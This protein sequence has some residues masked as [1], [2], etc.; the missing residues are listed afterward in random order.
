M[1][2]WHFSS[3]FFNLIFATEVLGPRATANTVHFSVE[4][5]TDLDSSLLLSW[6]KRK[7]NESMAMC[8]VLALEMRII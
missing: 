4:S 1:L 8:D 6:P 3:S 7:K 2:V 5:Y